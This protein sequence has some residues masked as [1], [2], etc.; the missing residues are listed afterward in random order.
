MNARTIFVAVL[1]MLTL[2]SSTWAVEGMVSHWKFDEGSGAI[3]Y[4]SA[5]T[6]D[7]T[8]NGATWATGQIDG[9][10]S[11]G[12]VDDYVDCASD[13]SLNNINS[14]SFWFKPKIKSGYDGCIISQYGTN[15]DR[16]AFSVYEAATELH[17]FSDSYYLIKSDAGS[18]SPGNWYHAAIT[19]DGSIGKM[20]IDGTQQTQTTTT[21]F[22]D[23]I[24]PEVLSIGI[25][26]YNS[27]PST[28]YGFNGKIDDVMIF[29]IAVSAHE[30][31]QLYNNAL[32]G[33]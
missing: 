20:Y 10:L 33:W 16:W 26:F 9:A 17:L 8:V 22:F 11:F 18:V 21:G 30:I 23:V 2:C 4:D 27:I 14:V 15:A 6:N 5:G 3:A 25:H 19:W 24:D 7:G 29:D 13:M 28:P 31:Q 12:G 1:G 32:A